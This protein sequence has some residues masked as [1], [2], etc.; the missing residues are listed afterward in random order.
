LD[1]EKTDVDRVIGLL[2]GGKKMRGEEVVE[3]IERITFVEDLRRFIKAAAPQICE[4]KEKHLMAAVKECEHQDGRVDIIEGLADVVEGRI[5][6][7]TKMQMVQL[8]GDDG[9]RE[10]AEKKLDI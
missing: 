7:I 1:G 10:R 3:F 5:D 8:I 6:A 9:Q 2:Q 4:F